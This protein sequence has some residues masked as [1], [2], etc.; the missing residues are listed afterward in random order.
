MKKA[1]PG[2]STQRP[3]A[4]GEADARGNDPK[5]RQILEKLDEP[6]PMP[7]A[8]ETPLDDV[9]KYIKQSTTTPTFQGIP[10]YVEPVGLQDAE[11]SL[12]STIQMDLEGVA[13]RR[14]LQLVLAQLDL[15]YFVED[16]FLVITSKERAR[17]HL[18]PSMATPAPIG[19]MVQKSE[20]G[21]LSSEELKELVEV[22]KLRRQVKQLHEADETRAAA[23]VIEAGE[24]TP[25]ADQTAELIKEL[26]EL[27]QLLKD[28]K[29][30]K[31]PSE[32]K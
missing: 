10:I 14:T 31:K 5:T 15:A 1:G 29:Q 6:I 8:N 24:S 19:L 21:E 16:G 17:N 27:I 18:P 7:F 12:N 22:L 30:A 9:L 20:R 23:K 28:E 2:A 26:R 11:R 4:E 13:L 32:S 3:V 25:K